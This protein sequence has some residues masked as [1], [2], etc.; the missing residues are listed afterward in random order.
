M[1]DKTQSEKKEMIVGI[2]GVTTIFVVGVGLG[3]LVGKAVFGGDT[4]QVE[5]LNVVTGLDAIKLGTAIAAT[6]K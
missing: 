4:I 2:V 5:R 3:L 1:D 6:T